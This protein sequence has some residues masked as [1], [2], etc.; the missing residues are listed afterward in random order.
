[1]QRIGRIIVV[2]AM[3]VGA[4]AIG[5]GSTEVPAQAGTPL[6]YN[7]S[8]AVKL[9]LA[10]ARDRQP[11][12]DACTWFVSSLLWRAGIPQDN[13]WNDRPSR[14]S[15]PGSKTATVAQDLVDHLKRKYGPRWRPMNFE[16]NAA[17]LARPGDIVAYDWK[18]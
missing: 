16:R 15:L 8:V 11:D 2:L 17:S 14:W 4:F 18:G 7:R 9:A 5:I 6:K 12:W 10:R 1:M 3:L 13:A